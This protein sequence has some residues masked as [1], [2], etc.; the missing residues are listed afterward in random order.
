[1]RKKLAYI[2]G[3]SVIFIL[4]I[5]FTFR[6]SIFQC[7]NPIPYIS[8]MIT[9]NEDVKFTKVYENKDIYITKNGDYKELH[10]YIENKYKVVFLEQMGSGYIFTSSN[11]QII[12]TSEIYYKDYQV[13]TMTMKS[14]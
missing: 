10:K 14:K 5:L 3:L 7:G 12:L 1:M 11:K 4:L 8:K 13:W 6:N 2:I 9:L